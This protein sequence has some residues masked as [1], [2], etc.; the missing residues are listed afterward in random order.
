[1][2]PATASAATVPAYSVADYRRY[3]RITQWLN[4]SMAV[5]AIA[6]GVF[7][8]IDPL[9]R[10]SPDWVIWL[11]WP[12]ATLHTVEEYIV[13]GG[14]LRYFNAVTFASADPHGP[15]T[16]RRAFLTDAVAGVANP[17]VVLTLS[18][19]YLPG[20]WFFVG[21]LLINGFFHLIE[22]VKTG[23]YF[24]GAGTSALLYLPGFTAI[25]YFYVQRGLV[26]WLDLAVTFTLAL[27]FTTGFFAQVRRWQR[28][29]TD[30]AALSGSSA[31]P[32]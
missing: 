31:P 2:S 14:F 23:R 4:G 6:L 25:T 29:D 15:L 21:V 3:T 8:L 30:A 12:I 1:M 18:M 9:R 10:T 11:V 24:P 32:A 13:P 17:I 26:S 5:L 16:A 22:T 19:V 20:I 27:L 28:L 7:I